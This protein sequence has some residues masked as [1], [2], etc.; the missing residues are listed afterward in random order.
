MNMD[1]RVAFVKKNPDGTWNAV[2]VGNIVD[3][4]G[5][6]LDARLFK[7]KEEID[8]FVAEQIPHNRETVWCEQ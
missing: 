1:Q 6:V 4:R 5:E 2:I 3:G 8:A 7:P